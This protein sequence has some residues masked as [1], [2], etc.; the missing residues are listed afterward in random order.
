MAFLSHIEAFREFCFSEADSNHVWISIA[1]PLSQSTYL[2]AV[3]VP[4][5]W[6]QVSASVSPGL[7][8]KG[9]LD[10]CN[11]SWQDHFMAYS[12]WNRKAETSQGIFSSDGN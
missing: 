8:T 5:G 10:R 2:V 9:L 11:K 7:M 4:S 6:C 3:C 12:C 1:A